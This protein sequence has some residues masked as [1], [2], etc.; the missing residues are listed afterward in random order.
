MDNSDPLIA[1]P[2]TEIIFEVSEDGVDGGYR[3]RPYS[4]LVFPEPAGAEPAR[5]FGVGGK[6]IRNMPTL[7]IRTQLRAI[8]AGLRTQSRRWREHHIGNIP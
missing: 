5:R 4:L 1:D 2:S 6:T 3:L 7:V 8:N